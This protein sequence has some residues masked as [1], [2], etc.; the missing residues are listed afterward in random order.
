[1]KSY[2]DIQSEV[3]LNG[4]TIEEAEKLYQKLMKKERK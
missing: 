1:M 2:G 4:G 3:I